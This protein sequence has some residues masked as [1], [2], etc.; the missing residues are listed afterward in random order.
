M[1]TTVDIPDALF[2]EVRAFAARQG[3]SLKT[4]MERALRELLRGP[5]RNVKPFRLKKSSFRGEGLQPGVSYG[6]WDSIRSMI[7]EGR[8]G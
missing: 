6:D 1:K 7:Y 4:V 2:R 3:V 8:G 5:G